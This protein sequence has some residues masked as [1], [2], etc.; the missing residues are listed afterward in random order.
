MVEYFNKECRI[1]QLFLNVFNMPKAKAKSV[2]QKRKKSTPNQTQIPSTG[3]ETIPSQSTEN[4]AD[5]P[6]TTEVEME[7]L[8]TSNFEQMDWSDATGIRIY[9]NSSL[10]VDVNLSSGAE[11]QP[12]PSGLQ[13]NAITNPAASTA[14]QIPEET[15][16]PRF[17]VRI[18]SLNRMERRTA[19]AFTEHNIEEE[20]EWPVQ[21]ENKNDALIR[22]HRNAAKLNAAR[23]R[24]FRN[25]EDQELSHQRQQANAERLRQRRNPEDQ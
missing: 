11:N 24:Q 5:Q 16:I 1:F 18:L 9:E 12:G 6:T 19:K 4:I 23:L 7:N 17:Q 2:G 21:N 10:V 20:Y 22:K 13:A 3:S 25:P 15:L 14:Q 8:D